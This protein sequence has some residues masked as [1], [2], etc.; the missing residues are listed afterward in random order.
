MNT[1]VAYLDESAAG[2]ARSLYA[3]LAEKERRS[4]SMRTVQSYSRILTHSF[5]R[6]GKT[7][8]QVTAQDVF[9]WAYG[10]GLSGRTPSSVTIGARIA[11]LSS[12]FRFL[13]RMGV[14]VAN[15]CDAI[16]RPRV[17]QSTPKGLSG[18]EIHRLLGI[19]PD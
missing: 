16:E 13:I 8:N 19:V 10:N 11:C 7:P 18:A 1:S 15:P 6:T 12:F 5:V 17:V 2:W 9:T 3:F 14:V 4:G